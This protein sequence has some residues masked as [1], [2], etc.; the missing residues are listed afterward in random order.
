MSIARCPLAQTLV[1]SETPSLRKYV[2]KTNK[3]TYWSSAT[4]IRPLTL[5]NEEFYELCVSSY[6]YSY[7]M[8]KT[9]FYNS[10]L[11]FKLFVLAFSNNLYL[12]VSP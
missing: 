3:F 4:M 7:R 10:F 8:F 6:I 5:S 12:K 1:I 11:V 9:G 2:C